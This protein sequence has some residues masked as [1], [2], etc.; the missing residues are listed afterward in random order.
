M[1]ADSHVLDTLRS[2]YPGTVRDRPIDVAVMSHDASHYRLTP[3]AVIT[4]RD[5]DHLSVIMSEAARSQTCVSFRSGGTSLSGQ[6]STDALLLDTRRSFRDITVL[7]G[8]ERVRAQPGATVR[9]INNRLARYGRKLGPDPASE[10]ACT[11]GGVIANNSSGM[12]CGTAFNT[13]HTIESAVLVLA[14]GLVIDTADPNAEAILETG[15]PELWSGLIQLRDRVREDPY[16]V[17][18]IVRQFSRKNTMGYSVNAFLDEQSPV[19]ILLRLVVGSEGTLAFVAEA[20]LRTLPIKTEIAT[21][22]LFFDSLEGATQSLP[23]LVASGLSAIEIMDAT[24]LRVAQ[25]EP[26]SVSQLRSMQILNHAALLVEYAEATPEDLSARRAAW[27]R[28]LAQLEPVEQIELSSDPQL[29]AN[30]W[31]MRKGLYATVAGARPSGTTALLEDVAVPVESLRDACEGLIALFT[32]YEYEDSV[33]F[34]HAKDGNIHF[35]LTE[36]FDNEAA[37]QRYAAFT[38]AMV[39]LILSFGGTLK[40]EHGTGRVMAPYVRRQYGDGIYDAMVAVKNLFDPFGVLNPGVLINDDLD[41]AFRN[42]KT[43]YPVESEV[44]RCVECGYCE[45]VCPSKDLT[46]TPR[47]RIVL[48]RERERAVLDGNTSL[49]R[50]LDREYAYDGVDTCAADGMCRTACPVGIDTGSLVKRLRSQRPSTPVDWVWNRAAGRWGSVTTAGAFALS[51][52]DHLPS[53]LITAATDVGRAVI[54]ADSVPRYSADLPSGG[55]KRRP[56]VRADATA[57]YVPSCI[58][59]MF[60]PEDGGMGVRDAFLALCDRVGVVVTIPEQVNDLCCGTPWTSKGN[61]AGHARMS[62]LSLAVLREA[63][64]DGELPIVCDGVSCSEGFMHELQG[65]G[66]TVIDAVEFVEKSI[67]PLLSVSAPFTSVVVHPTCSSTHLGVTDPLVSLARFIGGEVMVPDEWGCCGFA[68]DRGM[69]HPELTESATRAEAIAVKAFGGEVHASANRTCEL[70]MT[71]AT[72][73]KYHHIVELV[74]R[75]TRN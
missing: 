47:Q 2:E 7:D 63:T 40:A 37:V 8:G 16:F 27:P 18:E 65:S 21:G 60:A 56:Q 72:G 67:R 50:E 70:G 74:E 38:E 43:H 1:V 69:L 32:Q 59:S 9:A 17:K 41:A 48:R 28:V 62:E 35:M 46:L 51:I 22:L 42:M 75:A 31:H 34:G 15:T 68:G 66:L 23:L 30:L 39:A 29:R 54:G 33:I 5:T 3:S 49:V 20:T 6:A 26:D 73:E 14:N 13:Y 24:A 45:P 44:D 12:S 53:S 11:L 71:R 61:A 36:R 55:S 4:V 64:H 52:A 57:V 10:I 19:Q 25:R 58:G